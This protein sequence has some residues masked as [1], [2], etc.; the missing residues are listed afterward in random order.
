[1]TDHLCG[2]ELFI[3]L[4]VSVFVNVYRFVYVC[5]SFSFGVEGGGAWD[6]TVLVPDHCLPFLLKT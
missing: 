4:T 2:K 3:L 1:M 5:T 6:L